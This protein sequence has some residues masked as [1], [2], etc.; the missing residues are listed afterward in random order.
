MRHQYLWFAALLAVSMPA[1]A[2]EPLIGKIVLM[3]AISPDG[4]GK[5]I[6]VINFRDSDQGLIIDPDLGELTP[7]KHGL[8]IHENPNCDS[9]EKDGKKVAGLG[10][11]GHYDPAKTEKH[12]GPEGQG[13][14][15]DLPALEA[16]EDGNA[17][18]AMLAPHLKLEDIIGHSLIIHE[19]GDNYSDSPKPLGGGG[20]RVACGVID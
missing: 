3:N 14:L 20:A 13:H 8:H 10:A 15:G 9:G 11:G 18:H 12:E 17:V 1:P 16:D 2:T 4:I 19:G 6:G 7:G 5:I